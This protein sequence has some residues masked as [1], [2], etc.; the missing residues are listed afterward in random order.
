MVKDLTPGS[1]YLVDSLLNWAPSGVNRPL[2]SDKNCLIFLDEFF[3]LG[4]CK[5]QHANFW[6]PVA[7]STTN[8]ISLNGTP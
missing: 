4:K 1:F 6:G 7:P 3:F 5:R 8:G 2:V